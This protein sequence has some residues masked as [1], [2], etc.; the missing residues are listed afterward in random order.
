MSELSFRWLHFSDLH[1]GMKGQAPLWSNL[2]H[3]LYDDLPLLFDQSGPWDLVIFS[4]DIVQKGAVDEFLGA[5]GALTELYSKL[6]DLGCFPKFIAVPGNHDLVRPAENHMPAMLLRDWQNKETV[7]GEFLNEPSGP[8]RETIRNSLGNYQSWY[9]SLPNAGIPVLEAASGFLPGDQVGRLN[10]TG[11]Q[12][13]IVGL[14]STWLQLTKDTKAG[15]LHVDHLQL[16]TMLPEAESWCR[17]NDFNL[18]ITHHPVEW[19]GPDNLATWKT[20]IAPPGRFD[21]HL[22]GHM[23]E[24]LSSSLS[25]MGSSPI[26][27]FQSPSLFGLE[28]LAG[29]LSKRIHGYSAGELSVTAK[30]R[31]L[32]IWPRTHMV[33][34][35]GQSKITPNHEFVLSDNVSTTTPLPDKSVTKSI[36]ATVTPLI[37]SV[38]VSAEPQAFVATAPTGSQGVLDR[39]RHHLL[40]SGPHASVR[41][42]EQDAAGRALDKRCLWIVA[43]WGLSSDEFVSSV[44]GT[45]SMAARP[46]YRLDLSEVPV[47]GDDLD[48]EIEAKLGFKI[49][50]LSE[51]VALVGEAVLLFDDITLGERPQGTL[52]RELG[53]E[54]LAQAVLDYCPSLVILLRTR[55]NPANDQFDKVQIGALDE[56]DLKAYIYRHTDGG[57]NLAVPDVV[58]QLLSITG[59]VPDRVDRA[60]KALKVV[61]LSELVA[62]QE[63]GADKEAATGSQALLRAIEELGST[64]H[65]TLQRA[66]QMLQAL[67]TFPHG[68]QFEHIKRFNGVHGFY[69][70]NAT[71]LMQRAL[72]ITSTLPGFEQ[73]SHV[74]TR[75]ILSVPRTV[76]DVVR[77]QMSSDLLNQHNRRAAE[78]YF[79][80]NWRA[81]S[82]SWAPERKYSSPKCSHHEIAN[83]SAILLRLLKTGIQEENTEEIGA[84]MHL[85]AAYCDAL[86]SGSHYYGAAGFC[87]AF[88]HTAPNDV[89][90]DMVN[91]VR[92]NF[93]KALRMLGERPRS[94]EIMESLDP[95]LFE[96]SDRESLLMNL[97]LAYEG[98]GDE[99][100]KDVAQKLLK[101]T[102]TTSYKLQARAIIIQSEPDSS[103]RRSKLVALE[104]E[105]R[106]KKSYTAA[107]N[108]AITLARES[109]DPEEA[110]RYLNGVVSANNDTDDVYN[111]ARAAV[112]LAEHIFADEPLQNADHSRLIAAYQYLFI[113][114]IPALFDRC[115][116][117]LWRSFA[118]RGE[119][120]NLFA[121]F[122]HSSFIWRIR[123]IAPNEERY[124]ASLSKIAQADATIIPENRDGGYFKA[125]VHATTLTSGALT[126]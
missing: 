59:G 7:R 82:T 97:A 81:G 64:T 34:K 44:L 2:K 104:R 109:D 37:S 111:E 40:P 71:E 55:S 126:G 75:R 56:A 67:A 33:S 119:I 41:K 84:L 100:A 122:R 105:A 68:A 107:N 35:A 8:Y 5:T 66:L 69:P 85:A 123:G 117:A 15:D 90:E 92:L 39:F 18:L 79:G 3:H 25:T 120:P 74:E 50:Q 30:G 1:F 26:T 78:L 20:E 42:I 51:E 101:A 91:R 116:R 43:D 61:T 112:D 49:Q 46:V 31:Q 36:S 23:H 113:Q 60:L 10:I 17:S 9:E 98:N 16:S 108:L 47:S 62:S 27:I 87:S 103:A 110:R 13:G 76:R 125:R 94:I 58:G 73:Q 48:Q 80:S 28:H 83:A 124:I 29:G 115:H 93:G 86:L 118:Q 99:R 57:E 6:A 21:L 102:K 72:I 24:P 114:R 45:R 95:S 4:G 63:E 70:D 32:R 77:G 11:K 106:N 22:F 65:P 52:P 121:L 89:A 14:N 88:L 38:P 96:R 12:V 53:L 19:L 54:N